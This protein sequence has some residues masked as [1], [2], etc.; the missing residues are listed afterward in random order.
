MKSVD[1]RGECLVRE[2]PQGKDDGIEQSD[3]S[4]AVGIAAL[5]TMLRDQALLLAQDPSHAEDLVQATMERALAAASRF[6]PGTNLA[7]WLYTI[8]RNH[9]ID[10][11]RRQVRFVPFEGDVAAADVATDL[12]E[13]DYLHLVSID[14]LESAVAALKPFQQEI[15]QLAYRDRLSYRSI[16]SRLGIKISTVG[17]R[18]TRIKDKLRG[19]LEEVCT[20]RRALL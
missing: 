10:H 13:P 8:L 18:L 7:A 2:S 16:A 12:D 4:L 20:R 5:H 17:T 15:F 3:S 9:F 1:E 6:R 19:H 14:D 11:G